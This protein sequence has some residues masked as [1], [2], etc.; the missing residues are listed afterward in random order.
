MS[1]K[2]KPLAGAKRRD[3]LQGCEQGRKQPSGEAR[4]LLN[5]A[6]MNPQGIAGCS[7]QVAKPDL[8]TTPHQRRKDSSKSALTQA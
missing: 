3:S 4:T 5:I 7:R 8:C 1:S 6:Q 2:A